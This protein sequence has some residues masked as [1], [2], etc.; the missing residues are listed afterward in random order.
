MCR[1]AP[2]FRVI[3][4][5]RARFAPDDGSRFRIGAHRAWLEAA[6]GP[7]RRR[8]GG[9]DALSSPSGSVAPK[10]ARHPR[11]RLRG[12]ARALVARPALWIHGHTHAASDY[13]SPTRVVCNPRGYAREQSG[14]RAALVVTI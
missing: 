2:D 6:H 5:G 7:F 12:P 1:I 3:A 9:G 10:F 4:F 14:F 11:T 8:H 13:R